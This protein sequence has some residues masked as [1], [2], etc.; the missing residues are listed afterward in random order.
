MGI[1]TQAT[2]AQWLQRLIGVAMA[3][4]VLTGAGATC[5]LIAALF[6]NFT[7]H[8]LAGGVAL[9][10]LFGCTAWGLH[11]LGDLVRTI[12]TGDAFSRFNAGRLRLLAGL[13]TAA[14]GIWH[15]AALAQMALGSARTA[16]P[17]LMVEIFLAIL[18]LA[19]LSLAE[20]FQQGA[21]LHSESQLTV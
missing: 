16:L 19:L 1:K 2:A 15:L 17:N 5:L 21:K 18:I 9:V 7:L 4:T 6:Q 20:A 12:A 14:A 8:V 11:T 3:L 10:T 13:V